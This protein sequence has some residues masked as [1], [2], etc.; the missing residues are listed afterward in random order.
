M[1]Q[2]RR[3]WKFTIGSFILLVLV[4]LCFVP[5]IVG[6]LF[7]RGHGP[8]E[9]EQ[10]FGQS[11][12]STERAPAGESTENLREN[13]SQTTPG[14]SERGIRGHSRH[15]GPQ[16]ERQLHFSPFRLVSGLIGG[17]FRLLGLGLLALAA[18]I[19]L[20]GQ[21]RRRGN[22][23]TGGPDTDPPDMTEEDLKAAMQKL[24][25]TKLEV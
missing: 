13:R 10:S 16:F 4:S 20:G 8:F 1:S 22:D 21:S 18:L 11:R 7:S 14:Q 25:I 19:W 3:I 23:S 9:F 17:L 6:L 12:F 15:F 24:G 2:N 5:L